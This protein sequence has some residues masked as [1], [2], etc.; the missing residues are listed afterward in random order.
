MRTKSPSKARYIHPDV[1]RLLG[2]DGRTYDVFPDGIILPSITGADGSEQPLR[3]ATIVR[4]EAM[5]AGERFHELRSLPE[6]QRGDGWARD[7]AQARDTLL[8]L[9]AEFDLAARMEAFDMQRAAWELAVEQAK[10]GGGE[11]RGPNAA[12]AQVGD[13]DVRSLGE[14]FTESQAYK[15]TR[16]LNTPEVEVRNLLTG[17]S[18]G[19][20][21]S[22]LFVPVGSPYISQAG[23]RR[24]RMFLRDLIPVQGTG[25][26]SVP[27]IR[28]SNA[29]GLEGG[30]SAVQEASAKPEVT[31]Q[32]ESA[33]APIRKIAAWI[34]AT[35][36]ALEDAPTLRGYI[37][38]RLDYMLAIREEQQYLTGN[39]TAPQIKG[40]LSYTGGSNLNLQTVT[41]TS[42]LFVDVG[43]AVGKVEN[44]DGD[45]DGVV[46]NPLSYWAAVA[47]RHS[48][49][50]DGNVSNQGGAP[51]SAPAPTVWGLPAVR[52]RALAAGTA[53]VGAFG[54]GATIFEREGTTI[55]TSDSHASLFISNTSV[56][57]AEKR[58]GL[59]VHRPDFFV[60]IS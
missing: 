59:A 53:L 18:L 20:S 60:K 57:L 24:R 32:F 8:G 38:T 22:H 3:T 33:D 58:E 9:N 56:I 2:H 25:L 55:R 11:S 52:S 50:F 34:Q 21:N 19:T 41:S 30:A 6:S 36:E 15:D 28:E 26:T 35:M 16:G 51:F 5:S 48:T 39:G 49:W 44:V 7:V 54:V 10:K 23:I 47:A 31:A 27:Y 46:V 13:I 40:L 45:A 17:T 12:M 14:Q 4:D 42:D 43:T 1:R 29:G 37:D